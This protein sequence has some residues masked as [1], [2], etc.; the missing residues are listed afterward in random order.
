MIKFY[1]FFSNYYKSLNYADYK[2]ISFTDDINYINIIL[3]NF[4]YKV[5]NKIGLINKTIGN[6]HIFHN[7]NKL[8]E[9]KIEQ[10]DSYKC[11]TYNNN[12]LYTKIIC[13]TKSSLNTIEYNII[14]YIGSNRK[15]LCW[16]LLNTIKIRDSIIFTTIN[17]NN[18]KYTRK[19]YIKLTLIKNIEMNYSKNNLFWFLY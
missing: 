17:I 5:Y 7:N 2:Y 13:N 11:Y 12:N 14:E 8:S 16:R 19:T 4:I 3:D 10:G 18:L 1:V 9:K 6:I 15:I